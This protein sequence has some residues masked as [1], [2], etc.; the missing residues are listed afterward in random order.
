MTETVLV[1]DFEPMVVVTPRDTE[2]VLISQE[3]GPPGE[4]GTP[5]VQGPVGPIGPP[6]D[7]TALS[8]DGGNF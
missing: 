8:L 5:G 1:R 2:T 7:T 6:V 4:P 3:Q